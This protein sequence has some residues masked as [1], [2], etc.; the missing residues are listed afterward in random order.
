MG[1]SKYFDNKIDTH[2]YILAFSLDFLKLNN[3]DTN[4]V[5]NN[6]FFCTPLGLSC[7]SGSCAQRIRMGLSASDFCI[8]V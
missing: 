6:Q 5:K 7:L 2:I 8:L 4:L 3:L 1:T